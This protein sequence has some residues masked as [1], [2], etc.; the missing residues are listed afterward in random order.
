MVI[1]SEVTKDRWQRIESLFSEAL[2]RDADSRMTFLREACE[3]DAELLVEV[4][5]L[6]A[7]HGTDDSFLDPPAGALAKSDEPRPATRELVGRR[8]GAFRLMEPIA[9]GGMG[10]VWLGERADDQFQQRVAIKLM[11]WGFATAER[12]R[13]FAKERQTLAQLEHPYITRLIDGGTMDDGLPYLV[14]EYV[15]GVRI[16]DYCDQRRLSIKQ[17]LTLFQ[18]FC[19]AVHFA[20]QNLIVHRDLKPN[21]MLVTADG[22]PKLLDFGISKLIDDAPTSAAEDA[23]ITFVRAMTPRYASPE[24]IR[25]EVITTAT[26]V[27]SLGVL[28]YELLTGHRPYHVEP[29][30]G[31]GAGAAICTQDPTI[32]SVAVELSEKMIVRSTTTDTVTPEFLGQLRGEPIRQLQRRLRGDLDNI[33]LMALHQEPRKRY[34]SVQQ[35][36]EDVGRYLAGLPIIA[37]KD[38][39][40][41]RM[42]KFAKRNKSL[43]LASVVVLA[44]L[45]TG[46]V[47][48]T[49]SLR[50]K[51]SELDDALRVNELLQGVL[52]T[53]DR[54][55]EGD[56]ESLCQLLE[57]ATKRVETGLSNKPAVEA[58]ARYAIA[59]K[60]ADLYEWT[61]AVRNASLALSLN[62]VLYGDRHRSVGDCLTVLG[63]AFVQL[64][65]PRAFDVLE[66]ALSIRTERDG[67]EH[68]SVAEVTT[69]LAYAN[70]RV[71]Q[72]PDL[73]EAETLYKHAIAM[74]RNRPPEDHRGLAVALHSYG[75]M[76]R[77]TAVYDFVE[78]RPIPEY[79]RL[80]EAIPMLREAVDLY[81]AHA[82][83]EDRGL[84]DCVRDY[85]WAVRVVGD[86]AE[87]ARTYTQYLSLV[88]KRNIFSE[89]ERE[90]GWRVA[91]L[92]QQQRPVSETA[93][94]FARA[95]AVE[96]AWRTIADPDKKREWAGL[97]S[98]LRDSGDL[99][100]TAYDA[101]RVLATLPVLVCRHN[102]RLSEHIVEFAEY[103][104]KDGHHELAEDLIK[105][106]L[107]Y[108]KRDFP[109]K[110]W[111][112]A[113]T[114]SA[115]AAQLARMGR[116]AEAR[117]MLFRTYQ[118]LTDRGRLYPQHERR[119][120]AVRRMVEFYELTDE[121]RKA[122]Y[123]R[124]LR[125]AA[126]IGTATSG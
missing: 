67:A 122:D 72:P 28:L 78:F 116:Y 27:Y 71:K 22:Q 23:T 99:V 2:D 1:R 19:E 108:Q 100:R 74:Y 10:T 119:R 14:M 35:F 20:H 82:V 102:Q 5:R 25:G 86:Y 4:Q 54:Y 47:G 104:G 50:Q 18:K 46:V 105:A 92:R 83:R 36:S 94:A 30:Q 111:L 66:D 13:R 26:D 73:D 53:T 93:A 125:P 31:V 62:R 109:G 44:A 76:L 8:V 32:P 118:A 65:D 3:G 45:V 33:L 120:Q 95:L 117:P 101:K 52:E 40:G 75:L 79:P 89:H 123:Y 112:H 9:T 49:A 48:T 11:S 57:H 63:R 41:Y 16:D 56:K 81:I 69:Y 87:E 107:D 84:A 114:E 17:R 115:L 39:V 29:P 85:A 90:A 43:V 24:Q 12:R 113:T 37:R 97:A 106:C 124:G 91:V 42:V 121:P 59:R 55:A 60:Y 64:G 103:V 51:R 6:V 58:A 38:S 70:R 77:E 34:A 88:P 80:A 7:L 126:V 98:T 96:C 15:E 68:A 61:S 21:N 110:L